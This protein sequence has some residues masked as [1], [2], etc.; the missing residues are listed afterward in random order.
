MKLG[1]KMERKD[2]LEKHGKASIDLAGVG[3]LIWDFQ[4]S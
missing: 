3:I 1:L 4:L 2:D